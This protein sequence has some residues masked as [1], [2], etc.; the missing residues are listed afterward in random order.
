MKTA[1]ELWESVWSAIDGDDHV[2]V[3]RL[4]G[5]DM[6][7][8]TPSRHY[9]GGQ[10]LIEMLNLHRSVHADLQRQIDGVIESADGRA[11]SCE[12]TVSG[13]P[14][15]TDKR[16]SWVVVETIRTDG[17]RITS[18]HSMLDRAWLISEVKSL[19]EQPA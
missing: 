12:M 2:T 18:W 6:E 14:H 10:K 7:I 9:V 1:R 4:C 17:E 8:K 15:G 3:R 19:Q 5:D 13:R 16:L 11:L